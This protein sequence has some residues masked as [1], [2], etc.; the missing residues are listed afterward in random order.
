MKKYISSSSSSPFSYYIL[1]L[2]SFTYINDLDNFFLV[3][4]VG[5]LIHRYTSIDTHSAGNRESRDTVVDPSMKKTITKT[6]K[7]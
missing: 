6:R 2:L 5:A 4:I 3:K 1:Q 7:C